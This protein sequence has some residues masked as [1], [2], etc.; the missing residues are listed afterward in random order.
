MFAASASVVLWALFNNGLDNY[1]EMQMRA[2]AGC[3]AG[4]RRDLTAPAGRPV[5]RHRNEIDRVR[6]SVGRVRRSH[7]VCDDVPLIVGAHLVNREI[8]RCN[9]S[10]SP[11]SRSCCSGGG[12][13]TE[14]LKPTHIHLS[15]AASRRWLAGRLL[16]VFHYPRRLFITRTASAKSLYNRKSRLLSDI[17]GSSKPPTCDTIH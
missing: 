7:W 6:L 4:K 8:C 15:E 10:R 17:E 5:R 16:Q 13:R 9:R 12:G 2:G 14:M 3:S 11:R 1:C